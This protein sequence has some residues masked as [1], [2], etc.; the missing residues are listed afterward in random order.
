ME[1]VKLVIGVETDYQEAL[2]AELFDMDFNGFEQQQD[3]IITYIARENFE[4]QIREQINQLLSSYPGNGF[5]ESEEVIADQNW[6]RQWEETIRA[7]TI[8]QFFVEPTWSVEKTP[9]D[10]ILLKIDPKMSFGT[11]YHETTRLVLKLLPDIIRDGDMV[12]DAGTGTGILAIASIKLG[13]KYALAF[14]IDDWS[15]SNARENVGLNDVADFITVKKGSTDVIPKGEKADVLLANIERNTIIELLHDFVK[16]L[17][18]NG[19]LV[20]SG[21]LAKDREEIL[22]KLENNFKING[23]SQENEWIAI[24]AQKIGT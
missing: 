10:K 4:D 18:L 24:H 9:E 7:Q 1:Y 17:K 16:A 15:I 22:N 5:I 20:L 6:N 12:I 3:R 19:H 8:G 13:A 14:D 11:G 21:L 23:I 2:I